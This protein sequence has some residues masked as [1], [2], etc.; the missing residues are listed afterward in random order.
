MFFCQLGEF[1]F[2]AEPVADIAP[3]YCLPATACQPAGRPASERA[4][5]RCHSAVG[6]RAGTQASWKGPSGVG[7]CAQM[8]PFQPEL[9][10]GSLPVA[11]ET[12]SAASCALQ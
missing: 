5:E 6:Q 4:S 12:P 2:F 3:A 1:P 8:G 9:A 10:S 11:A 7:N